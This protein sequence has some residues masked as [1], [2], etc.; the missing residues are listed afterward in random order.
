MREGAESFDDGVD[1]FRGSIIGNLM[2]EISDIRQIQGCTHDVACAG[3][4]IPS[5]HTLETCTHAFT[6][7]GFRSQY[8]GKVHTEYCIRVTVKSKTWETWR[9]YKQFLELHTTLSSEVLRPYAV[10]V[11][12]TFPHMLD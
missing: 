4:P 3:A 9:R 1:F 5:T 8:L 6:G 10:Q 11:R 12:F 7:S 2:V